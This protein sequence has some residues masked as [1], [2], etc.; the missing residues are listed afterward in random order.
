MPANEEGVI[1]QDDRILKIATPFDDNYLLIQ[2]ID[3]IEEISKLPFAEIVVLHDEGKEGLEPTILDVQKILGQP[4]AVEFTTPDGTT[5]F[6]NGIVNSCTQLDRDRRFTHYKLTVVPEF[7]LLTQ[8]QRSRTFQHVTVPDILKEVFGDFPYEANLGTVKWKPRNYLVQYRESDFDFASRL[9]EEEGIFYYFTHTADGHKM[10]VCV[11]TQSH[12]KCASKFEIPYELKV[13]GEGYQSYIDNFAVNY[14]LQTGK[15]TLRDHTHQK[16]EDNFEVS[17][18]TR[19]KFGT[20]D[21]AEHYLFPSGSIRKYD[22]IDASN[23]ERSSELQN[24]SDDIKR[25]AEIMQQAIDAN[26]RIATGT[27]NCPALLAGHRFKLTTHPNKAYNSEYVL[28]RVQHTAVQSPHYYSDMPE[29]GYSN[30]FSCITWGEGSTPYRPVRLTPKPMILTSQTATV[31]GKSGEEIYTDKYGRVKVQFHWDR[32][33]SFDE[34]SSCWARVAQHWAGNRWG[35]MFIPRVGMEVLVHFLEGDP[36]QPIIT[37]CV[38]K[39]D[40]MP[41][42]DLPEHKTKSGIKTDSSKGGKGFNELRFE[43]KKGEEQVFIHGQKDLDVRIKADRREWIGNDRHLIVHRDRYET[44]ERDEHRIVDR[45]VYESIGVKGAGDYHREVKGKMALKTGGGVSH[46]IGGSLGEKVGGS[47]SEEASQD[48]Y[49]KAGM[50][51]VIEAGVQLTLKGP[52]GFVDI[53]PAGVTIQGTMV[54]INSGGAAGT[55]QAVGLVPPTKPEETHI[56]AHAD[57]GSKAPTYK[58][59]IQVIPPRKRPTYKKPTHKPDKKKKSWIEIELKDDD[60]NPVAGEAYR[61]EV[62]DGSL[63]EGSLD[64]KGFARVEGIDP[65][66]CKVSFPNR[67]KEVVNKG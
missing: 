11:D 56:A 2:N 29:G 14:R 42:Y 1:T 33:G 24:M 59:Q 15:V 10:I 65:G 16:P 40:A 39:H 7:W 34:G 21:N 36:D 19:F 44:V 18:P 48:I 25:N 45:H 49:L 35:S 4:V 53:G 22:V 28:T 52:G 13:E 9:M 5:R 64:E 23:G 6:Y 8:S 57:P 17:H 46:S 43:D 38:Y 12:E 27:S 54:L 55:G 30:S 50:K 61:V 26:H 47:H 62:P 58:N 66:T 20:N 32:E 41:P 63:A 3:L 67:D 31:V 60:G 51:V 37:G